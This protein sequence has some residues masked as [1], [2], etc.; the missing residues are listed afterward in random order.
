M[1]FTHK[2]ADDS[3][4]Y[5][6]LHSSYLSIVRAL[7]YDISSNNKPGGDKLYTNAIELFDIWKDKYLEKKADE[8]R[9]KRQAT[10]K[11]SELNI[12]K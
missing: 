4:I 10:S 2:T 7:Y 3:V 5:Q 6:S 8:I 12:K 1:N 9:S 11:G